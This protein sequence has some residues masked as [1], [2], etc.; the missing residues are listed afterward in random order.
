MNTISIEGIQ[1]ADLRL[2]LWMSNS[3][4][5]KKSICDYLKIKYNTARL[6]KILQTFQDELAKREELKKINRKKVFSDEEEKVIAKRYAELGSMAKTADEFYISSARIKAILIRQQIP[7]KGRKN[8]VTDH[9]H[10][11]LSIGFST[12]EKVFSKIHQTTCEIVTRYD[13][14][15]IEYLK[16]GSIRTIDNQYIKSS[17]EEIE[18]IHY[19]VYWILDDG[20]NMGLL[21]SVESLISFIEKHLIEAGQEY[22]KVKIL[23]SDEDSYYGYCKREDLFKV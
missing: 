12:G 1:E 22:Y 19:T 2:A 11:D 20:T 17:Q 10:Q 15:Y 21:S 9:I 4:K 8:I 13:E 3:G 18:N 6:A 7:I 16:N 14:D 23:S 5:T